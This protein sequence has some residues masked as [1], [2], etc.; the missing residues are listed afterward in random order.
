MLS[1]S[2]T[3]CALSS[4]LVL[5]LATA[6]T[7]QDS[8]QFYKKPET[9][10]E[11]WRYMNHEIELGHFDIASSYLKG[12][13]AKNP[14]DDEI[15]QMQEKQGSSAFLRLLTIPELQKDAKPLVE[16]VGNVM[17]KF[18]AD[19]KRLEQ[20]IKRLSSTADE[21]EER[22]FAIAQLRRAG[23]AAIPALIDALVGTANAPAEHAA[24]LSALYKLDHNT[25][26]PLAAALGSKDAI[27]QLEIL[28][29]FK[30][31][32]EVSA[33]PYLWYY[34]A[35]ASLPDSVRGR[36]LDALGYLL[37]RPPS[38]LPAAKA[39]LSEEAER[40]YQHQVSFAD[41]RGVTVWRWDGR[42]E[43][44]VLTSSQA[45]EYYGLLFA[46]QALKLDPGYRPAQVIY[47]SMAL[48]KGYERNGLD[49]P[50]SKGSPAVKE[51]L[52]SL[53]PELLVAVLQ[54]GIRE[55]RLGVILGTT[56]A[57]GDLPTTAGGQSALVQALN[58][59]D[60]RIQIAAA[61]ALLRAPRTAGPVA[62]ARIVEV[63]RR[64]AGTDSLPRVLV[65]DT[66]EDRANAIAK[67]VKQAG[68]DTLVARSGRGVL[69]RLEEAAD[70]DALVVDSALPDPQLLDLLAQLRADINVGRLPIVVLTAP[71]ALDGLQRSLQR[72]PSVTVIAQTT[73]AGSLKQVL[74]SAIVAAA[75]KALSEAERRDQ[76]ALAM[77]WLGRIS[78]GELAGYD[79]RPAETAILKGLQSKELAPLAASAAGHFH[80]REA[81]RQLARLLLDQA[82]PVE[83]RSVAAIELSRN[84]LNNGLVLNV[85][86]SRALLGLYETT[87]DPKLRPQLALVVGSM[88]P[89]ARET[90]DRLQRYSPS[91]SAPATKPAPNAA[92]KTPPGD[93]D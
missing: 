31:R 34:S 83:L 30:K 28:D 5:G 20:H 10:A 56:K 8:R 85:E 89:D 13:L 68:F 63:L 38:Q 24:I 7:A 2:L 88:R 77:E 61:D 26:L 91:F 51:L 50:L 64:A 70:I 69:A 67:A 59:P 46:G 75:G 52:N 11:F 32:G 40:Y 47:L 29:V 82:R 9:A 71:A 66:N 22:A 74:G 49:Q 72:Y 37:N 54:K 53:N 58:Y 62:P 90:G 86:Q 93:N 14:T 4:V 57:L 19:R 42:L 79:L 44:Q 16:R 21:P 36:A 43:S 60:R 15:I 12:F 80:G 25:T 18:L 1:T 39:A 76:A 23:A 45:E 73:D 27:L 17:Q 87:T 55:N 84:I 78:R 35:A 6:V 3:R 48:D 65:A 92:E 41:P 33:V 81:Q